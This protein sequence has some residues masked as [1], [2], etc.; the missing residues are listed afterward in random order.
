MS[1]IKKIKKW[2]RVC[3]NCGFIGKGQRKGA[4]ILELALWMCFL[5]PGLIYTVWR[6]T[7]KKS[8]CKACGCK[9]MLPVT[10]PRGQELV[11]QYTEE[12]EPENKE[13]S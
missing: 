9:D 3:P 10:T 4:L 6:Y 5:L 11:A 1:K 2:M 12:P 7:G 13:S 8:V